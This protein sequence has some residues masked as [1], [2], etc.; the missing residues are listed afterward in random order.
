M[1]LLLDTSVLIDV[2]RGRNRRR[3]F[4][5]DLVRSGHN[6][7]TTTVNIAEIYGGMRPTEESSTEALL[8]ELKSLELN[9]SAAKLAGKL[10]ALWQRKG[11]TLGLV[12]AIVAAIAIESGSILVTDNRRDFPMSEVQ[13]YPLP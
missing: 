6:L 2:L 12:D 1:R 13:L 7:S 11:H 8:R 5:A 3:E 9:G 10:K 4:L